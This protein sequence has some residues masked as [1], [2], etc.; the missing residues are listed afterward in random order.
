L[1][2][3]F[4]KTATKEAPLQLPINLL[5]GDLKV[6]EQFFSNKRNKASYPG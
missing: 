4:G 1:N 3:A 5:E 6:E 2:F